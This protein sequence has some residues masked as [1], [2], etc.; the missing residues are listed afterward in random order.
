MTEPDVASSDASNIQGSITREGDH[1]IINA[2]KW[3]TS[4]AMDLNVE[5]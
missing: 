1:Y 3:W 4:G 5:Y 2:T